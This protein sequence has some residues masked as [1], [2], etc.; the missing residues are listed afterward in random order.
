MIEINNAVFVTLPSC[1]AGEVGK[2]RSYMTHFTDEEVELR[3]GNGAAGSTRLS[4]G[5][6]RFV[7]QTPPSPWFPFL[8]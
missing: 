8:L 1:K 6:L 4:G 5:V 2:G 3:R 7:Y